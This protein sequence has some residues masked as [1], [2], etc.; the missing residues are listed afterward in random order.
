MKKFNRREAMG[1]AA[2][3]TVAGS[4]LLSGC[5]ENN[6]RNKM[7]KAKHQQ[8]KNEDFYK[9]DGSF[10]TPKAKQAYYEMME[11]FNYPIPERLRS[12]EF[13]AVDFGLGRFTEV[14]MA[15][16]LW[17]NEQ[18]DNYM[19]H[20]I[21]LLPGQRIPEHGHNKTDIAIAKREGWMPRYGMIHIYGEGVPT[22]GADADIPEAE[23]R[24]WIAKTKKT[25]MPGEVGKLEVPETMHWM[26]AGDE[27]A[28]VTEF[29][30]FH[31]G[32]ALK[33]SNPNVSF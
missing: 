18:E 1:I 4:A 10:D 22:P 25:L 32:A 15:G 11:Y 28:I 6:K 13:W 33:F 21:F 5:A 12:E 29:A 16:I 30:T 7:G 14:G 8:Y 26:Y 20:E 24:Y 27:G 2:G 9:A 31:D 17:I 19:G 3:A 23:K